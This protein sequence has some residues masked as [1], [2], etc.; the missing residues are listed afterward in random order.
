[1]TQFLD[2]KTPLVMCPQASHVVVNPLS[3]VLEQFG[4]QGR[5]LDTVRLLRQSLPDPVEEMPNWSRRAMPEFVDFVRAL[6]KQGIY[7]TALLD[8]MKFAPKDYRETE[9]GSLA[10]I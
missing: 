1:M 10:G 3:A 4:I 8:A 2:L 9:I 6:H 5:K 7:W